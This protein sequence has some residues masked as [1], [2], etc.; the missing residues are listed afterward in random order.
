MTK[1]NSFDK[2]KVRLEVLS[3]MMRELDNQAHYCMT[4]RRDND[5]HV[6]FDDE[7]EYI[8]DEPTSDYD[9]EKLSVIRE[10]AKDFEKWAL[11]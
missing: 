4:M 6:I 10:L 11:K 9:K 2:A 8:Y 1:M 5:G 3:A 7:G